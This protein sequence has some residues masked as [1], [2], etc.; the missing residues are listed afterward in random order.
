MVIQWGLSNMT[1]VSLWRIIPCPHSS[2][3]KGFIVEVASKILKILL[4]AVLIITVFQLPDPI[5]DDKNNFDSANV[6]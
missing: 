6:L 1:R 4:I 3:E 5:A 2:A